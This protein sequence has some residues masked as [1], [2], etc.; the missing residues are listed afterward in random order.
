M[1]TNLRTFNPEDS[2]LIEEMLARIPEF[3]QEDK[4]LVIE[5]LRFVIEQPNQKDYIFLVFAD[6]DDRPVGFACYGPTP[7]TKGTFD[8]YWIAVNPAYSGQG[9]GTF[10]LKTVEERIMKGKDRMLVI[11]TSSDPKYARTRNFYLKNGYVL[12]ECL[13]DFYQDGEDRVTYTKRLL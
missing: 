4:N 7:L 3:D 2:I 9:I 10:L 13:H 11:E 8:L 6:S 1:N 5:L 12:A